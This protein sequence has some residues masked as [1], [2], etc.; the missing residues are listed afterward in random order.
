MVPEWFVTS[1]IDYCNSLLYDITDYNINR[2]QFFKN[3][4][5]YLLDS[6]FILLITYKSINDMAPEYLCEMVSIKK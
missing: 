1:R 6:V 4:N 5:G 2:L 3:Y